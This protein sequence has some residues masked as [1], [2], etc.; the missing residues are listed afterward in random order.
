M[1]PMDLVK[2]A[3]KEPLMTLLYLKKDGTFR[4]TLASCCPMMYD[5]ATEDA[6]RVWVHEGTPK[7]CFSFVDVKE[8]KWKR[9][10]IANLIAVKRA[11]GTVFCVSKRVL[12]AAE[13]A[14][15]HF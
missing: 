2:I 9:L 1:R 3:K 11:D 4:K 10:I 14:V 8:G 13:I 15:G 5:K 6:G 7:G 12:K